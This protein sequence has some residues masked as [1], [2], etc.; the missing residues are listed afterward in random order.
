[1]LVNVKKLFACLLT[2]SLISHSA[3]AFSGEQETRFETGIYQ[4]TINGRPIAAPVVITSTGNGALVVGL[5]WAQSVGLDVSPA[6]IGGE[7]QGYVL[8]PDQECISAIDKNAGTVE[9][10]IP[11]DLFAKRER[12]GSFIQDG[13]P[14]FSDYGAHLNYDLDYSKNGF[15]TYAGQV[16][17]YA[18]AGPVTLANVA[19]YRDDP[20]LGSRS[21]RVS[22]S[23]SV[24]M[25]EIMTV[26]SVGDSF[27][28]SNDL[29]PPTP[30][31]GIKISSDFQTRPSFVSYGKA[32][33]QESVGVSSSSDLYLNNSVVAEGVDQ[34][35]LYA[36]LDHSQ[37]MGLN[38]IDVIVTDDLGRDRIVSQ[39]FY[40]SPDLLKEGLTSY[41][42]SY[43]FER[44]GVF[45]NSNSYDQPLLSWNVDYGLKDSLNIGLF[46]ELSPEVNNFG[47]NLSFSMSA[48]GLVSVSVGESNHS[49]AN[50]AMFGS[51]GY[52]YRYSSF[53]LAARSIYRDRGVEL[54]GFS[55]DLPRQDHSFNLGFNISRTVRLSALGAYQSLP[56]KSE[57]FRIGSTLLKRFE[58]FGALSLSWVHSEFSQ[59]E[60]DS[61]VLAY[62]LPLGARV[63][64][65]ASHQTNV[66]DH[67]RR[68][69]QRYGLSYYDFFDNRAV[70]ANAYMGQGDDEYFTGQ[71]GAEL[72][73]MD[74]SLNYRDAQ[75]S[76]TEPRYG[77]SVEGT[78]LATSVSE[79]VPVSFLP[80][81]QGSFVA[82]GSDVDNLPVSIVGSQTINVG[83]GSVRA[84]DTIQPFR[85]YEIR[86]RLNS[87]PIDKVLDYQVESFAL[88]NNQAKFVRL[89]QMDRQWARVVPVDLNGNAIGSRIPVFNE[90]GALMTYTDSRGEI[91]IDHIS[92]PI[93]ATLR[94]GAKHC[95]L[96]LSPDQAL[97][98]PTDVLCEGDV[99]MGGEPAQLGVSVHLLTVNDEHGR[100]LP[101]GSLV[102]DGSGTLLGATDDE[103]RL[104]T[105][106]D[107]EQLTFENPLRGFERLPASVV[108]QL[109]F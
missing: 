47:G 51:I 65:T 10:T 15:E 68:E 74:V 81:Q 20:F 3:N 43:G 57:K 102:Y 30:F 19:L 28:E 100:P 103:S 106:Q 37:Q 55:G 33:L 62:S 49:G 34:D 60:S 78:I 80:K 31:L 105:T 36:Y 7:E 16:E 66:I 93:T 72:P 67:D 61:V 109:E 59:Q 88:G 1:M 64:A 82:I 71:L 25:P 54:L 70:Y 90:E 38:A 4:V 5:A 91:Y 40:I 96:L 63:N 12:R 23:A 6:A 11:D 69:S 101:Q 44:E 84:I 45:E 46:Q 99:L 24:A 56:D 27:T 58:D 26:L 35:D 79:F 29:L 21:E 92:D 89:T 97:K 76:D 95:S 85:Q 42:V 39:V 98:A 77:A 13:A 53:S 73:F 17:F 14:S 22:S 86:P 104:L 9:L 87:L 48:L 94:Q 75:S 18:Y 108:S 50:Q 83:Q 107:A 8:C 32:N 41:N 52:E 2:F